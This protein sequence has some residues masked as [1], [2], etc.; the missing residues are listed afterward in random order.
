ERVEAPQPSVI[1]IAAFGAFSQGSHW[2]L[3]WATGRWGPRCKQYRGAG[4]QLIA[5]LLDSV[6]RKI[7]MTG[8]ASGGCPEIA[9]DQP[10]MS[11]RPSDTRTDRPPTRT[12]V[13]RPPAT[14]A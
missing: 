1:R 10:G 6:H 7:R 13:M 14:S 4:G 9:E 5:R 8:E 2:L 12:P 11:M 3:P